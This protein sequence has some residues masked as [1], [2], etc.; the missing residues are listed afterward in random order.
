MTNDPVAPPS[1]HDP[2]DPSDLS[3]LSDPGDPGDPGDSGD[4][5][6]DGL[7]AEADAYHQLSRACAL[8]G[9]RRNAVLAMWASDVRTLHS[10]LWESGIGGAPDPAVQLQACAHAVLEG[11]SARPTA[12]R[13]DLT[14]RGLLEAARADLAAVFDPS[15]HALLEER[16]RPVDHLDRIAHDHAPGEVHPPLD[17]L[18]GRSPEQLLVDLRAA[19][20]DCVCVAQALAG[21]GDFDEADRQ[22]WHATLAAFEAYLVTEAI[23]AGDEH[24]LTVH[25]RWELAAASLG[26]GPVLGRAD[27][28]WLREHLE[29][30]CGPARGPAFAAELDRAGTWPE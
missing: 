16:L 3:D 6:L 7:R 24:Q 14:P 25:L 13:H 15:V 2:D 11:L 27:A 30:V 21:E 17:R 20:T 26:N 23:G 28:P 9:D 5:L 22:L 12:E 29:A 8:R 19:A 10:L 1:L 4:V 18:A